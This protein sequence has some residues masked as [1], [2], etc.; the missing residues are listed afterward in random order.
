MR[1][2]A[3]FGLSALV[4]AAIFVVAP[5]ATVTANPASAGITGIDTLAI[6]MA[7]KPMPAQQF[8]AF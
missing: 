2:T 5:K 7:A 3:L 6:T 4:L 1:I 8:A